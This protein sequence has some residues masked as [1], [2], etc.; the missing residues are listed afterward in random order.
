MGMFD[1]LLIEIEDHPIELKTK[2]F[3]SVLEIYRTGDA[4]GGAPGGVSVFFDS[5]RVDAGYRLVWRDEDAEAARA[6][7]VFIVLVQGVFTDYEVVSGVVADVAAHIASLKEK[8]SDGVR[9]TA[10]WV[11]FLETKQREN[12]QLQARLRRTVSVLDYAERLR[13]GEDLSNLRFLIKHEAEQRLDAGEDVL[14]VLRA[15]LGDKSGTQEWIASRPD[16]LEEY[17]L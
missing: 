8:W 15:T 5:L 16:P 11:E 2:R 1:T 10:R 12:R 7:T 14:A 17:R 4:V 13:S 9:L 6:F 3:D